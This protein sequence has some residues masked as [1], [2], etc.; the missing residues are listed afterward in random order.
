MLL[1]GR[2]LVKNF[3]GLRA[4]SDLDISTGAGEIVGLIG[5]NG[6]G[7]TTVVNLLCGSLPLTSGQVLLDGK[8]ISKLPPNVR[9]DMGITRTFQMTSTWRH[10]TVMRSL[11]TAWY[12]HHQKGL[13]W[14]SMI[15]R[16]NY[17]PRGAKWQDVASSVM[18][19]IGIKDFRNQV[20]TDLTFG[21]QR[22]VSI[23]MALMTR[24]SLLLLD[25]PLSG[26]NWE[27]SVHTLDVVKRLVSDGKI[28]VLLIEHNVRAVVA[29]ATR[30]VAISFGSKLTEGSA[31][32]VM[33]NEKVI[34]AYLGES[35]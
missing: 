31:E 4:V 24:P 1:E 5:P 34:E 28:G 12:C 13:F 25:E 16:A 6:A 9:C 8:D 23:G 35:E 29:Y 30:V 14:R 26:M 11:E 21:Q 22:L 3:G 2:K 7:K 18:D 20:V 33:K 27:E 32:D 10:S 19:T 15:G 17:D